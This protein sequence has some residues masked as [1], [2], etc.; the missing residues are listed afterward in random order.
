MEYSPEDIRKE[1]LRTIIEVAIFEGTYVTYQAGVA[2]HCLLTGQTKKE[3]FAKDSHRKLSDVYPELVRKPTNSEQSWEALTK[4]KPKPIA[5]YHRGDAEAYYR[6]TE[7]ERYAWN[8]YAQTEADKYNSSPDR[9]GYESTGTD[10]GWDRDG[11]VTNWCPPMYFPE[12]LSN[13]RNKI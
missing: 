13:R 7:E 8:E 9:N 10:I 2:A 3:F 5:I 12:W 1:I 11:N 6:A 4:G